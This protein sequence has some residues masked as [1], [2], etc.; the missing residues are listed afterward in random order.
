[1]LLFFDTESTGL[2]NNYKAPASD[3]NNWPRLVQ[4][5]YII[6]DNGKIIHQNEDIVEPDGF[7]IPVEASSIHGI[8]TELAKLNGIDIVEVLEEFQ[9]WVEQCDTVIG[10][11]VSFDTN[12]IGAE[13]FRL[14][15]KS[16]LEGKKSVCTMLSGIEFCQLPGKYPGKLKYPKLQELYSALFLKPMEQTHTALDD[17]SHTVE[18]YQAMAERGIIK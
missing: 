12:V 5:G 2:P 16:P 4:L 1:M 18:C 3:I 17:I 15:G 13:Y 7:E 10:H 14:Y 8:T 11:N 9:F 6:T